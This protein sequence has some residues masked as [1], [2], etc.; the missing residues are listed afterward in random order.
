M[1]KL[2]PLTALRAFECAGRQLSFQLAAQELH[3]TPSA[4]SHQVKTLEEFLG[5]R[6]FNRL[7]RRIELTDAG[8]NYSAAL[9]EALDVMDE[10]TRRLRSSNHE[11]VL[12]LSVAPTFATEWLVPRLLDFQ[13]Q[14]PEIEVRLATSLRVPDFGTS[15]VDLSILLGPAGWSGLHVEQ[16][17]REDLVLLCTPGMAARLNVPDD[18]RTVTLIKILA[19][20]GQWHSWLQSTGLSRLEGL[21]REA[22]MDSTSLAIEAAA[23]GL[24]VALAD[25]ALAEGYLRAGTLIIPFELR[26]ATDR[27]YHLICPASHLQKTAVSAFV[28]WIREQLRAPGRLR[29]RAHNLHQ[30]VVT[31]L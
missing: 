6:L 9:G 24:G 22:V 19:R 25:R 26:Q 18:L 2:P 12:M 16:L 8:R 3:V 23:A 11:R 5:V 21:P 7:T 1:R 20:P 31:A 4:I 27:G 13:E 30:A 17:T 15:D 28:E 10:A 14:Y 29:V